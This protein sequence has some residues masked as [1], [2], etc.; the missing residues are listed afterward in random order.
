M[1]CALA[2]GCYPLEHGIS[3]A[4]WY[5][6]END[7]VAYFGD[8]FWPILHEGLDHYLLDF[9]RDL[10]EKR[11]QVP[12]IFEQLEQHG[13]IRDA[14]INLF[15]FRG[16]VDHEVSLPLVFHLLPGEP[17]KTIRGPHLMFMGDFI[18]TP[19]SRGQQ[20]SARGG[21]TRRFGFHDE[22]TADYLL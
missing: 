22:N 1:F 8:D 9:Q 11:L 10:N 12:T 14:V 16:T 13:Q 20:L 18:N 15:W 2:T 21:M 4:Y 17:A 5:D 3:G 19:L 7:S 6:E